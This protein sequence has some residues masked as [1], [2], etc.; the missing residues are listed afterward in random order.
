MTV[1][2]ISG[3]LKPV[4]RPVALGYVGCLLA[5]SALKLLVIASCSLI[6]VYTHLD[7]LVL[8]PT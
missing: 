3:T 1:W 5:C 4:L 8:C 2:S 7:G 6:V